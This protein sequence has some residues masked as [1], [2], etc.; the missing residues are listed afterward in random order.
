MA[1]KILLVIAVLVV[2]VL[3]RVGYKVAQA[4]GQFIE[5]E[6]VQ[7]DTCATIAVAPGPEDLV[8][9]HAT[10]F[11][12]IA[13]TDRRMRDPR[14]R[15]SIYML[16][17]NDP[18]SVPV[19]VLGDTPNDFFGHGVSLWRGSDGALRLFA[20]N[21]P[22]SGETVEIFDV[23]EDGQLQHAETIRS[24]VMH[25]LNDVVAVGPRQ[26]YATN[27]Q[28]FDGG[29]GGALEV[30]LGL[31]LG[32]LVYFDGEEAVIAA[33][34]FAYANG[35]NVSLDG[36]KIY[37]A[38]TIGHNLAV[39]DRET[40]TG[41]LSSRRDYGLSTGVDNIDVAP[42]GSLYIGAHPDLLAFT[43]HAGD[44]ETISPS[45]VVRFDPEDGAITTVYASLD[46]ELNGS[47]TGAFWNGTLLVSGVF[48]P[49]LA[50]CEIQ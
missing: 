40:N 44:P 18:A 29:I 37:V 36:Q 43:A 26:F 19:E 33:S 25:S 49:R 1:K 41:E 38:E 7:A 39:F 48:E 8:I 3:G 27:D 45:Q 28:R 13:A 23:A 6:S 15:G 46:G 50:R 2:A 5:I 10:G 21:H 16:D 34:G 42:D 20:V 32:D 14:P 17:L 11:A 4:S 35:V 30:F 24:E 22:E 47:A 12:F 9:D 31:P